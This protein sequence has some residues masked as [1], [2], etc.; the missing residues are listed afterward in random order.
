MTQPNEDLVRAGFAAYARGDIAALERDFFSPDVI[1]H[2]PGR[3]PHAGDHAGPA[4]I[5]EMFAQLGTLSGGTHRLELHDVIANENQ[6]VALHT[7]RA[8][9]GDKKLEISV[10]QVFRVAGGRVT[11][12]WTYHADLYKF[13]AFWE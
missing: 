6:V 12:A 8:E 13:D 7:T 4:K 5:A 1:W 11:E 9:R 3:N 10:V 2:F